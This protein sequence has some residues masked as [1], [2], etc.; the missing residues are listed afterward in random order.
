[1]PVTAFEGRYYEF[2]PLRP[3]HGICACRGLRFALSIFFHELLASVSLLSDP[4]VFRGIK[5]AGILPLVRVVTSWIDTGV[6]G[7][8]KLSEVITWRNWSQ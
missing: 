1:M 8:P 3:I 6:H 2:F 7:F 4:C 5:W